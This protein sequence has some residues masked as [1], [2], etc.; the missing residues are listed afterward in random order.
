MVRSIWCRVTSRREPVEHRKAGDATAVS[1]REAVVRF[2]PSMR[3]RKKVTTG[4]RLLQHDL[5]DD[6]KERT[7]PVLIGDW[8]WVTA[9]VTVLR[10]VELGSHSV[11]TLQNRHAVGTCARPSGRSG[12][13][14]PSCS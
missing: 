8:V 9:D 10:G 3:G 5:D 7:Q 11:S 14:R 1:R 13:P 2:E 6:T 12:G 4:G